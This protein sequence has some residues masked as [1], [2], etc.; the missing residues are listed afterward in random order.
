MNK[1]LKNNAII[2]HPKNL[3]FSDRF[4]K[5]LKNDTFKAHEDQ[6]KNN[7][8]HS[9]IRGNKYLLDIDGTSVYVVAPKFFFEEL[10]SF[11]YLE[12]NKVD[13]K[14]TPKELIKRVF[15]NNDFRKLKEDWGTLSYS[16]SLDAF[17]SHVKEE[18]FFYF[19]DGE[20]QYYFNLFR[21]M[22]DT[23]FIGGILH[24]LG[25]R[26]KGFSSFDVIGKPERGLQYNSF[27][28][29]LIK[30]C[31]IGEST[32]KCIKKN[33][34]YSIVKICKDKDRYP[35]KV[36]LYW[37]FKKSVFLLTTFIPLGKFPYEV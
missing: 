22:D 10:L 26:F 12:S 6:I 2:T 31:L 18:S 4:I 11:I 7:T 27:M 35:L 15:E 13:G 32:D 36:V 1:I 29:Q 21:K 3:F 5:A 30:C 28:F 8:P 9:H 23:E 25:R 20:N 34:N 16:K 37:D 14:V 33:N 19:D 24:A 17:I